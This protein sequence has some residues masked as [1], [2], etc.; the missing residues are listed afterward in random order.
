MF[1]HASVRTMLSPS[2]H[3]L[4]CW[5]GYESPRA[6]SE[7]TYSQLM[8]SRLLKTEFFWFLVDTSGFNALSANSSRDAGHMVVSVAEDVSSSNHIHSQVNMRI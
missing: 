3:Q 2:R 4:F 8:L 6:G 5:G 1:D 7:D